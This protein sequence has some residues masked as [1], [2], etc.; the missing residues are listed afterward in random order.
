MMASAHVELHRRFPRQRGAAPRDRGE[1]DISR[2]LRDGL[3]IG[4]VALSTACRG[5]EALTS[6]PCPA[7]LSARIDRQVLTLAIGDSARLAA[8]AF[9][10]A[11]TI[12]LDATWRWSARDTGV[13]RVA[14]DAGWIVARRVGVT[15]VVAAT[16]PPYSVSTV[17]RVTV[18]P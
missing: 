17:A 8:T 1:G 14:A 3:V 6:V 7:D 9:R 12:P 15:E 16:Q 10:C 11:G 2:R 18:T 4:A 13:V 5:P